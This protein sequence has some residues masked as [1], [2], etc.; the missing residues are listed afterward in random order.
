MPIRHLTGRTTPQPRPVVSD[1][2]GDAASA[3]SSLSI[4]PANAALT[5]TTVDEVIAGYR[6]EG[7][8][9]T[10]TFDPTHSAGEALL[11]LAPPAYQ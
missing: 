10:S 7:Y 5:P 4:W 1:E 9:S 2:T 8:P 6:A 3:L 11:W